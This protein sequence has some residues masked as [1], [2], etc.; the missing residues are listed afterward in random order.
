MIK[1]MTLVIIGILMTNAI[2]GKKIGGVVKMK[3]KLNRLFEKVSKVTKINDIAYHEIRDGRLNPVHKTQTDVLGVEKWKKV[4]AQN[5]VYIKDTAVLLEI[6]KKCASIAINDTKTHNLT[7]DAFFLFGI[8]SILIAPVIN[9]ETLKG[10][11]CIASI[12][13]THNFSDEDIS[14]CTQ[15]VSDFSDDL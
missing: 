11:V 6:H 1:E 14:K 5:P 4:H 7:S 10:I 8:D 2:S 9:N 15:L 12:G 13:K 3:E